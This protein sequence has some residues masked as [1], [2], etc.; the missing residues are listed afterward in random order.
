MDRV[1]SQTELDRLITNRYKGLLKVIKPVV[2]K[3]DQKQVRKALNLALELCKDKKTITGKPY[4]LHAISVARI[5]IEEIGLGSPSIICALMHDL[6]D[7]PGF[8]SEKV[9]EEFGEQVSGKVIRSYSI[10]LN[11][12]PILFFPSLVRNSVL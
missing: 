2:E 9:K 10:F 1:N 4:V 7:E 12:I 5:V 11:P 3:E 6:T 8:S